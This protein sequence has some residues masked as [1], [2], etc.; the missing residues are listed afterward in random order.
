MILNLF[1]IFKSL[2]LF[3]F[4]LIL[5]FNKIIRTNVG[6]F[7]KKIYYYSQNINVRRDVYI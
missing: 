6:E 7:I 5:F 1:Y 3:Y 2:N 4:Y